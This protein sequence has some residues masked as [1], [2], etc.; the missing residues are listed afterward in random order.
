MRL[1]LGHHKGCT[2]ADPLHVNDGV[3]TVSNSDVSEN[4]FFF[5]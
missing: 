3:D 1:P 2:D 5:L 4:T